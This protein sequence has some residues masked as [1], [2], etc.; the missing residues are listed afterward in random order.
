[1][2]VTFPSL[3]PTSRSFSAPQWASTK[4]DS[5]SGVSS[6]RLWGSLPKKGQLTLSF[7]NISDDNAA[8][9]MQAYNSAQGSLVDLT[10]PSSIFA[11][12]STNLKG[13]LDASSMS[14]GLKWYFDDSQPPSIE[15]VVNGRSSVRVILLAEIRLQ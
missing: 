12:A 4:I 13:W 6:F 9:I 14:A 3:T 2:A 11:G 1:M 10:L 8:L 15:S 7:D 5:Q